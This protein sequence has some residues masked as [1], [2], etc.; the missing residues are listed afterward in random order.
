MT[1]I[2]VPLL[3]VTSTVQIGNIQYSSR[4]FEEWI[5]ITLYYYPDAVFHEEVEDYVVPTFVVY[6]NGF[7]YASFYQEGKS[8]FNCWVR[9]GK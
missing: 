9:V 1:P 4:S 2:V 8:K 7:G 5:A 3:P 6:R